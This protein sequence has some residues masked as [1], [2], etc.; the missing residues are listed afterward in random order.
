MVVGVLLLGQGSTQA[1]HEPNSR[2]C[3]SCLSFESWSCTTKLSFNMRVS[4]LALLSILK[5]TLLI[6]TLLFSTGFWPF[7]IQEHQQI[8]KS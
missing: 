8:L 7:F 4:N 6:I 3:S 2:G 1:G 5:F